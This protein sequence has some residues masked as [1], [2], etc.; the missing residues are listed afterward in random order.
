MRTIHRQQQYFDH[1]RNWKR[2]ETRI[3]GY[4]TPKVDERVL[5]DAKKRAALAISDSFM[6]LMH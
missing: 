2:L 3:R 4:I 5:P 6:L 1:L